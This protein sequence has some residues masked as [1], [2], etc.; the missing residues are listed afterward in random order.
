[1]ATGAISLRGENLYCAMTDGEPKARIP[2]DRGVPR[3]RCH[4]LICKTESRVDGWQSARLPGDLAR[5][6]SDGRRALSLA[7]G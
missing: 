6:G 7:L 4:L 1:M 2:P 3:S 5:S